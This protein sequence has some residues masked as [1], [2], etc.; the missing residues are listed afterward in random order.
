FWAG[1]MALDERRGA[2]SLYRL[3]PDGR[4]HTMVTDVTVS[5]GID[6]SLDGSRMYY[7]DSGARSIDVFDFD[8]ASRR[9]S[10]RRPLVRIERESG[11]PDGLTVDAEGGIWLALWR[12]SAI[13]RYTP[14]GQ[15]DT[16]VRL[17][18]TH[19]T[20]CAFGGPD[21]ADLYISSATIA[22][23]EAERAQQ[24]LAGHVL[25]VRPGV[26]GRPAHKFTG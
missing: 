24:P 14:D 25:R 7:V 8:A 3:D 18:V 10:D 17:P 21:L 11:F 23:S 26:K 9:L 22:L 6:W 1:T 12:G 2:G 13:H 20:S 19:A 16:V 5:N 15:L 4:V